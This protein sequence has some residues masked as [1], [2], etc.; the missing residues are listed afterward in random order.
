MPI[1]RDFFSL[2]GEDSEGNE[3]DGL[4]IMIKNVVREHHW[5]PHIIGGFFIDDQDYEGLEY[6]HNDVVKVNKELSPKKK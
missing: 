3:V 1:H 4:E 6:W 5:P 2:I